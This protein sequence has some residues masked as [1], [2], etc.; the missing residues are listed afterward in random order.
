MPRPPP[1]PSNALMCVVVTMV[2]S[3]A[4]AARVPQ[5]EVPF[6]PMSTTPS[7]R[8]DGL[9]F[10]F[11]HQAKCAGFSMRTV[12]FRLLLTRKFTAKGL[13]QSDACVPC[14]YDKHAHRLRD[15]VVFDERDCTPSGAQPLAVIAGHFRYSDA[16]AGLIRRNGLA[17]DTAVPCMTFIRH[18]VKRLVSWY[19]WYCKTY[20]LSCTPLHDMDTDAAL[21]AI[22]SLNTG[23]RGDPLYGQMPMLVQFGDLRR[24]DVLAHSSPAMTTAAD[25]ARASLHRCV[26]G[27]S[28]DME[29]SNVLLRRYLPWLADAMA[30]RHLPHLNAGHVDASFNLSRPAD[31]RAGSTL[32]EI[33]PRETVEALE[34]WYEVEV[35]VYA[36]ALRLH[37]RQLEA[38]RSP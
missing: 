24:D 35:G 26:I 15:C 22:T 25:K 2:A 19:Y 20:G 32:S 18:P 38:V 13:T 7:L 1:G 17:P 16:V 34:R 36:Y 5:P 29:G 6:P 12:I 10:V 31:G 23:D 37:E 21:R 8:P 27:N 4:L 9:P 30:P 33:I 14:G 11:I 28:D 3:C